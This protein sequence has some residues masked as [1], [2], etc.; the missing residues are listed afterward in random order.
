MTWTWQQLT[1]A[2]RLIIDD[3]FMRISQLARI[4]VRHRK[5][6]RNWKRC[7]CHQVTQLDRLRATVHRAAVTILNHQLPN[8]RLPTFPPNPDNPANPANPALTWRSSVSIPAPQPIRFGYLDW[9]DFYSCARECIRLTLNQTEEI[10]Q[11]TNGADQLDHSTPIRTVQPV[12]ATDRT[13]SFRQQPPAEGKCSPVLNNNWI[14]SNLATDYIR[15]PIIPIPRP[16]LRHCSTNEHWV[17]PSC[18]PVTWLG[19]LIVLVRLLITN[20]TRS[21]RRSR[22]FSFNNCFE[23]EVTKL[24]GF[25]TV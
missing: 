23:L 18:L 20:R 11:E 5:P 2:R 12:K 8:H 13:V 21:S 3:C 24:G 6:R 22:S 7:R 14:Y 15:S 17:I 16:V 4:T 25:M 10:H 9:N 19:P 1:W